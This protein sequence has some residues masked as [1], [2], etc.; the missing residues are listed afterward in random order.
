VIVDS[1]WTTVA[2]VDKGGV[3]QAL[4]PI[5][6]N[7]R[8]ATL[9]VVLVAH[10]VKK[11]T[12]D[13]LTQIAHASA[14]T[15]LARSGFYVL[16]DRD[17][18]PADPKRNRHRLVCHVKANLTPVV[19]TLTFALEDVFLPAEH[20]QVEVNTARGLHRHE[21]RDLRRRARAP[22]RGRW[23]AAQ[24]DRADTAASGR[25]PLRWR[26]STRKSRRTAAMGTLRRPA[27]SKLDRGTGGLRRYALLIVRPPGCLMVTA[28][29][30]RV[31]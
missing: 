13:P 7:A 10:P 16:V 2:D 4:M 29:S 24:Q 15:Q 5:V 18:G 12:G 11:D 28:R 1:A 3:R 14:I 21:R 23:P 27:A 19:D 25:S 20:G 30:R 6:H 31:G 9:V 17:K 8:E 26:C 22:R